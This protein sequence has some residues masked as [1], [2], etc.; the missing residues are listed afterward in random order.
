M[1]GVDSALMASRDHVS[2]C[3]DVLA[4]ELSGSV[5]APRP[6]FQNGVCPLFVTWN[7]AGKYGEPRLR[8]CIG[9]LEAKPLHTAMREY[10]LTS[11]LRDRRFAPVEPSELPHL[12]CTVSLLCAFERDI[13]PYDWDVGTHGLLLEFRDPLT[14]QRRTATFLPEVALHQHWDRQQTL[15]HL[16][17]KAGYPGDPEDVLGSG[18]AAFRLT[19]YQST[20]CSLSYPEYLLYKQHLL[21][22]QVKEGRPAHVDAAQAAQQAQ[23]QAAEAA[24]KASGEVGAGGPGR[25]PAEQQAQ[26]PFRV[27]QEASAAPGAPATAVE[28]SW[29][30]LL[31]PAVRTRR[32]EWTRW[33]E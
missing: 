16:I 9:T 6:L 1:L 11:A 30:Q 8:G 18:A 10:S 23:L 13:D 32:K 28:L 26:Q 2:F 3:F 7:K 25:R 15:E 27:C 19:R 21:Q 22:R 4:A 12:S 33:V 29:R 20:T 5:P 24:A 31:A 17:H 14:R